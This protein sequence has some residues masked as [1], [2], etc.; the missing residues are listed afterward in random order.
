MRYIEIKLDDTDV[1]LLDSAIIRQGENLASALRINLTSEFEG[2]DYNIVFQPNT[3][4]PIISGVVQAVGGVIEYPMTNALTSESGYLKVEFQALDTDTGFVMKNAIISLRIRPSIDGTITEPMPEAYVTWYEDVVEKTN[5]AT[6]KAEAASLSATNALESE[7]KSKTSELNSKDS[8][9]KSKV[10]E[11]NAKESET[12]SLNI[13]TELSDVLVDET[14]RIEAESTRASAEVLRVASEETRTLAETVRV[15]SENIRIG[16]EQGRVS[17]ENIRSGFYSGFNTSLSNVENSIDAIIAKGSVILDTTYNSSWIGTPSVNPFT[18]EFTLSNHGLVTNDPVE[19]DSLGGVLP[20]GVLPYNS[21]T[22]GGTYY[23]A[24]VI[25]PNVFKIT[26]TVGGSTPVIPSDEG[27]SVWAVRKAGMDSIL[28]TGL[29]L[30][31]HGEYE[32]YILYG[33]AKKTTGAEGLYFRMNNISTFKSLVNRGN[34]ALNTF[35]MGYALS[36]KYSML[37]QNLRL[38]R[39]SVDNILINTTVSG[40][41]TDDKST[42]TAINTSIMGRI[43]GESEIT[44]F[45]MSRSSGYGVIRNGARVIVRMV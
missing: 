16:A 19:F 22:I 39:L 29:S 27:Q 34:Y 17:A 9:D 28:P 1:E 40:Q 10:S 13:K 15:A 6:A 41:S 33:F 26:S 20:S 14:E 7:T 3:S 38:K 21:D 43:I 5:I 23:N 30:E 45:N 37:Y 42:A 44:S 18:G 8:E 31:T 11:D 24:I 25:N 36:Q 4:T 35:T 32:I 2:Y 12:A